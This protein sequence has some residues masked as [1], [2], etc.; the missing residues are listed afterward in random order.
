M[1]KN[2][3]WKINR[4]ANDDDD[5]KREPNGR[6]ETGRANR[7]L[8]QQK[9]FSSFSIDRARCRT[10]ISLSFDCTWLNW[11]VG[12][13]RLLLRERLLFATTRCCC[14]SL[15]SAFAIHALHLSSCVFFFILSLTAA[16][17]ARCC[18]RIVACV[19]VRLHECTCVCPILDGSPRV[20]V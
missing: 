20:H 11:C 14:L 16:L 13:E 15:F 9:F 6:K 7:S 19:C 2:V 8:F 3:G 17:V 4:F 12:V 1:G 18:R 5:E 10:H